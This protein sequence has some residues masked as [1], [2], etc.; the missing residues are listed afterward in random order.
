MDISG[1]G[2]VAVP[3]VLEVVVEATFVVVTMGKPGVVP[4]GPKMNSATTNYYCIR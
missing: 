1:F 3:N 4:V 2:V